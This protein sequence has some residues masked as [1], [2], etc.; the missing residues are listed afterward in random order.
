VPLAYGEKYAVDTTIREGRRNMQAKGNRRSR[1]TVG[2]AW[3]TY[4][5]VPAQCR[6]VVHSSV[7]N[8]MLEN[9]Q[10]AYSAQIATRGDASF[11]PRL[12]RDSWF[13]RRRKRGST[14]CAAGV[15]V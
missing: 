15:V 9:L 13:L 3:R 8:F 4:E 5:P 2:E 12:N 14:R 10:S 11:Y 1:A 6:G 7:R